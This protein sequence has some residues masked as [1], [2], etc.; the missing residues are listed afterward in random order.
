[1]ERAKTEAVLILEYCSRKDATT[2]DAIIKELARVV[3]GC[4]AS[5]VTAAGFGTSAMRARRSE[6]KAGGV[7][8]A[9]RDMIFVVRLDAGHAAPRPVRL[10]DVD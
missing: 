6:G 4:D 10:R 1:M 8:A 2:A 3:C 5:A 9:R 7:G